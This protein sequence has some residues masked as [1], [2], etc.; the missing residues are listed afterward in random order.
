[1]FPSLNK[2]NSYPIPI[3]LS[4]KKCFISLTNGYWP[5]ASSSRSLARNCFTSND[6]FQKDLSTSIEACLFKHPFYTRGQSKGIKQR[7]LHVHR[8]KTKHFIAKLFPQPFTL[9]NTLSI[10]VAP[11]LP[12][13]ILASFSSTQKYDFGTWSNDNF[14]EIYLLLF[15]HPIVASVFCV[16]DLFESEHG[17]L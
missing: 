17:F 10:L 1:M 3:R 7:A 5:T 9:L 4:Q 13:V 12:I 6:P 14:D 8:R 11:F 16:Q 15:R 2:Q